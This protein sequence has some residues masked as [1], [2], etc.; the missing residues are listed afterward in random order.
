MRR[1]AFLK[2][3]LGLILFFCFLSEAIFSNNYLTVSNYKINTDKTTASFRAVMLSD[4]HGKEF[5]KDNVRLLR[6]VNSLKPDVIFVVGDML[7][8]DDKNADTALELYRGL[9]N[10]ADVYCCAGNHE[11]GYR[12]PDS[13]YVDIEK[14]G[15]RL[16]R[17]EMKTVELLSGSFTVGGLQ[18]YPYFEGSSPNTAERVFLEKFIEQE[19]ENFSILLVHEPE[20]FMWSLG[21]MKLDLVLSG[22]T[23]GGI[24]R[25]PFIGGLAAPNQGL[26]GKNGE[27]LPKYTKGLYKTDTATLIVSAGLSNEKAVPRLNNPPDICVIDVNQAPIT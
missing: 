3:G 11:R 20:F 12:K 18:Y 17:N 7:N 26:L 9:C 2:L 13:L 14:T 22:H 27:L 15:A 6:A 16:L 10:I 23:H 21:K 19:K 4:L 24:I 5:G 8:C 1:K 25:L